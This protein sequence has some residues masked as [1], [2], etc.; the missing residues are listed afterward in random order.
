MLTIIPNMKY[1]VFFKAFGDRFLS[2]NNK[3]KMNIE[4][5]KKTAFDRIIKRRGANHKKIII[6]D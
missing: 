6:V 3:S 1:D 2:V 5:L 4:T